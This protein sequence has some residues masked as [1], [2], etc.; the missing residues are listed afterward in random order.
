[1]ITLGAILLFLVKCLWL[2]LPAYFANM[3]ASL[4]N[5][6]HGFK[7]MEYPVDFK[8]NLGKRRILG[9]H[10][11]FRGYFFGV[12]VAII[13][14]IIQ[15]ILYQFHFFQI[16]S[17]YNY[18]YYPWLFGFLLGLGALIGD[19]LGAFIKRR[20]YYIPGQRMIVVDQ[21]MFALFALVLGCFV[22]VPSVWIVLTS[23]VLTFV[24][25]I[26]INHVAFYL[27]ITKNKW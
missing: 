3:F 10:K 27:K 2:L 4:S 16:L 24:L 19:S 9:D 7:F 17:F 22:F 26:L 13:I 1:M 12:L 23:L 14:G 25:H 8:K 6:F 11:T 20:F 21:I 15:Y 5:K 18:E